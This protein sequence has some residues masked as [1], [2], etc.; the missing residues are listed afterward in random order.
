MDLAE[1]PGCRDH[2]VSAAS[3]SHPPTATWAERRIAALPIRPPY[4][5]YLDV[6]GP[7][8]LARGDSPVG[9]RD[10]THRDRVRQLLTYLALHRTVG[11]R[12]MAAT[13]W[14]ELT[15]ERALGNLRVNLTH[16][17]KVLQP[18]RAGSDKPWFVRADAEKV[19]LAVDGVFVDALRFESAC[20][21]ARALEGEGRSSQALVE[22][23]RAVDLYRGEY[24]KDWPDAEWTQVERFRLR[25]LAIG[26]RCRL[27]E[28]LLA[29][30]EPEEAAR[31][32]SIVLGMEP[33]QERACRLLVHALTAQGDRATALRAMRDLS[34]QLVRQGLRLEPATARLARSFGLTVVGD[35]GSGA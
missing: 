20:D 35:V 28:L 29:R 10:W 8:G 30:G 22:L 14:P 11:R 16:L 25:T 21:Q 34:S 19:S 13:L 31:H 5:L 26:T 9:D 4:D 17:Q 27:G 2:L 15:T 6:L 33:L 32:A 23:E 24:L 18:A 12:R 1:L 3:S 7:V